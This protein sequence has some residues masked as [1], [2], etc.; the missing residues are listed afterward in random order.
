MKFCLMVIIVTLAA[1]LLVVHSCQNAGLLSKEPS[2][3]GASSTAR[4][5]D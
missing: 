1:V 2:L 5:S 3:P 4:G